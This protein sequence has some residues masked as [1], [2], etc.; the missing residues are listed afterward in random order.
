MASLSQSE[1]SS[2][3]GASKIGA[4]GMSANLG[5]AVDRPWLVALL[6]QAHPLS[7]EFSERTTGFWGREVTFQLFSV[8]Q[9]PP[10][11]AYSEDFYVSQIG[12]SDDPKHGVQLRLSENLC[13]TML[14]DILGERED[15][16]SPHA[17]RISQVSPFEAHLF[18]TWSRDLFSTLFASFLKKKASRI[19]GEAW[20]QL[21]WLVE[22]DGEAA[23]QVALLFPQGALR[24]EPSLK[25]TSRIIS[26]SLLL[27]A[28]VPTH[29]RVG[30]A[31]LRLEDLQD[32]EP[33][34]LV[35]LE[36]SSIGTLILFNPVTGQEAGFAA[37]YPPY[38]LQAFN[39]DN[40]ET[41]AMEQ[42][43]TKYSEKSRAGGKSALWD[44]LVVNIQAEFEPTPL[45]LRELKQM[46]EGLVVEVGDLVNNRIR[47]HVEG[48]TLAWGELV[49]VG[50]KFGVLI[51]QVSEDSQPTSGGMIVDMAEGLAPMGNIAPTSPAPLPDLDPSAAASTTSPAN[52]VMD[53]VD[54]FLNDDFDDNFEN[55]DW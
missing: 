48:R 45:P 7:Q 21:V 36:K 25:P 43:M 54:Q 10:Y 38:R 28:K 29:L 4:T 35:V 24:T 14:T 55:G 32:L 22:C 23:G 51:R 41:S 52:A 30:Q 9:E 37:Q 3:S 39:P 11:F 44:D 15:S 5:L 31:G 12:L 33:G 13:A 2:V 26:E 53:E 42:T 17:F 18:N 47:L 20:L 19:A 6:Q 27:D 8:G 1:Q 49:I 16:A 50:D 40:E 46:G 34:D